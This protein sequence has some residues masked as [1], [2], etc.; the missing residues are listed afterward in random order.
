MTAAQWY[1]PDYSASGH[2]PNATEAAAIELFA[3]IA[4][5]APEEGCAEQLPSDNPDDPARRTIWSIVMRA[6]RLAEHG[7]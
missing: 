7:I 1:N 3:I 4:A 5:I 6:V 2:P